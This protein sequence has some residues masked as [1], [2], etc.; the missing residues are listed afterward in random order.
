MES[1]YLATAFKSQKGN[2]G[3]CT[4]EP[5]KPR[6]PVSHPVFEIFGLGLL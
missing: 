6:C 3:K 4:L 1:N 5:N 2:I